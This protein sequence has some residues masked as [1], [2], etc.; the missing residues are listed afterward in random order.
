M[1]DPTNVK[2]E[3]YENLYRLAVKSASYKAVGRGTG[4]ELLVFH[5]YRVSLR[6]TQVFW[7]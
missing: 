2:S 5:E 4:G 1:Y 3:E 7:E 6:M